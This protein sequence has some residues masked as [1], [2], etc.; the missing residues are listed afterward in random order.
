[1]SIQ[2]N[3]LAAADLELRALFKDDPAYVGHSQAVM[4]IVTR[5]IM[6]EKLMLGQ[7]EQCG[8]DNPEGTAAKCKCFCHR[9]HYRH[10]WRPLFKTPREILNEMQQVVEYHLI[11]ECRFCPDVKLKIIRPKWVDETHK[12][13]SLEYL[14]RGE[15]RV[16]TKEEWLERAPKAQE[17]KLIREAKL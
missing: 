2:L 16:L 14:I 13:V 11:Y 17:M 6:A 12:L 5:A 1:M 15:Q 8:A 3:P 7:H 9:G 10:A 4:E